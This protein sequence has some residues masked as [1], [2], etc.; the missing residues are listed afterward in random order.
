MHGKPLL[1][2]IWRAVARL[3]LAA[4]RRRPPQPAQS[5]E[6]AE[7]EDQA[8]GQVLGTAGHGPASCALPATPSIGQGG[9][10]SRC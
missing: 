8:E 6:S 7:A 2:A 10:W 5:G 1:D 9:R 3:D 4:A